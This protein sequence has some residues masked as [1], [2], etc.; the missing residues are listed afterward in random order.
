[1][2]YPL[3]IQPCKATNASMKG[4]CLRTNQKK[5]PQTIQT[6]SPLASIAEMDE[7]FR[8]PI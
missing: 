1:V 6:S 4:K 5:L 2:E 8:R 7:R 3:N